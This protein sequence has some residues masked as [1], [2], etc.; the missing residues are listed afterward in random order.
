MRI[1]YIKE[2]IV[3]A[4]SETF[5][6]AASRLYLSQPT[7]NNH[8]T[9]MEKDLGFNLVDRGSTRPGIILTSEGVEFL[10]GCAKLVKDYDELVQR[11]IQI[12]Q[13][14]E[15]RLTLL[16]GV[17]LAPLIQ[18]IRKAWSA[19]YPEDDLRLIFSAEHAD[20]ALQRLESGADDVQFVYHIP[21]SGDLLLQ[22]L[23]G[24]NHCCVWRG[25]ELAVGQVTNDLLAGDTVPIGR[26][27]GRSFVVDKQPKPVQ[28]ARQIQQYLQLSG[29]QTDIIYTNLDSDDAYQ[30]LNLETNIIHTPTTYWA[31]K[32][33]LAEDA[34][35]KVRPFE[36]D[37]PVEVW[38][39]WKPD[40]LSDRQLRFIEELCMAAEEMLGSN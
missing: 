40:Y 25:H 4:D 11:C 30:F 2:F 3:L 24:C 28:A 13:S 29:V 12:H 5:A 22:E 16:N 6:Q 1:S 32:Y 33:L 7:L 8:L 36:P 27:A 10:N 20:D 35:F 21:R 19:H 38:A 23:D 39:V 18:Q 31:T 9:A 26:L 37:I 34:G 15:I 14:T 17:S